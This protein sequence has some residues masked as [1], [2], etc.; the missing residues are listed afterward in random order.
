MKSRRGLVIT[1]AVCVLLSGIGFPVLGAGS[2]LAQDG[3]G[4]VPSLPA[5]VRV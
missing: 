1:L 5:T 2:A 4:E 3:G